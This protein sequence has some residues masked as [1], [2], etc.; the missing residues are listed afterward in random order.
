MMRR[1]RA[2]LR[3]SKGSLVI[4]CVSFGMVPLLASC[5]GGS[6]GPPPQQDF[7]VSV[8]PSATSMI[9]GTVSPPVVITV[10]GQNGFTGQVS[11]EI[12]G[13]P[14]GATSSPVTPF[15]VSTSGN[16]QVVLFI[17]PTTQTGTL[18]LQFEAT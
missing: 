11:I 8:T 4:Y 7:S 3:V 6:S 14:P 9:V 12:S 10:A 15:K 17:P 13:L 5:G 16:Q 1:M 18:S 2:K